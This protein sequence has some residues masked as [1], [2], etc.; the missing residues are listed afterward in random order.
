MHAVRQNLNTEEEVENVADIGFDCN[1]CRPYMPASNVPSS[2]CCGSS[3]VAQ[4]VTKVKELDPPKTYT[5]DGVCLT[6][7][8]M[9]QLQSLTVAVPR[10][11][12]SK[13]KLKLKIINQKS[14]AILQTPPDIQSEHSRDGDMDD[15]REGELMDCDGKSESSPEREAVDDETKGVEGTDGVKK[16]KRKPYRP[17]IGGF[18]VRQRSRTGQG[19][20]KRSVIRKDSSGSVSEQLPCRD[21]EN[22]GPTT[23]DL[24]L[25]LF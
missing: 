13:P 9:T 14:V 12:L 18:M 10:R 17:G 25:V 21:D 23:Q 2:D 8:G 24:R 4:I 16:R 5:Q 20:T 3:L 22:V 11:K 1:M 7:S 15:S 6:E 19:K